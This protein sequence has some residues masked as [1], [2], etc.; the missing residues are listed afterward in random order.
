MKAIRELSAQALNETLAAFE[1]RM[2][3]ND[4]YVIALCFS[5]PISRE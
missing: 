3:E 4:V 2:A 5:S 1:I